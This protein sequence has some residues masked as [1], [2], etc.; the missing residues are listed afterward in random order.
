M[1]FEVFFIV[2]YIRLIYETNRYILFFY[3][4][5][6]WVDKKKVFFF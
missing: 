4:K 2:L 5:K 1:F 3:V 6:M